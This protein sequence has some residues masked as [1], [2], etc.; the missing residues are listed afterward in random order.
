MQQYNQAR[1][2]K[3]GYEWVDPFVFTFFQ[4]ILSYYCG[5]KQAASQPIVLEHTTLSFK[6]PRRQSIRVLF[7]SPNGFRGC[8]CEGHVV[9]QKLNRSEFFCDQW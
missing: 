5:E 7:C 1:I 6:G 4:M 8:D 2:L 9:L 3:S